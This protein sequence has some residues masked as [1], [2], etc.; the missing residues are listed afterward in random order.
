MFVYAPVNASDKCEFWDKVSQFVNSM[1]GPFIIMG[2]FNELSYKKVRLGG[3]PFKYSRVARCN[4]ILAATNF[5]ELE[6]FS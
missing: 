6:F 5:L 1:S 2:D 3:A 4:N